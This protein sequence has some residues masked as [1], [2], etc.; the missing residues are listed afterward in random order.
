MLLQLP[1]CTGVDRIAL[2]DGVIYIK[3]M[4]KIMGKVTLKASVLQEGKRTENKSTRKKSAEG[5][6]RGKIQQ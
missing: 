1:P 5:A 3:S 6:E 4:D 2:Q